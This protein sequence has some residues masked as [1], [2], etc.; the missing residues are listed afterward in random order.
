[1]AGFM[2]GSAMAMAT[3]VAEGYFSISPISLKGYSPG[4]L[5]SLKQELDKLL[6]DARAVTPVQDD[7]QAN[8]LRNRK[9]T[10]LSSALQVVQNKLTERR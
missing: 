8:Q 3:Q 5:N 6:R 10:R 1:M 7:A 9:I 4:D 2:G